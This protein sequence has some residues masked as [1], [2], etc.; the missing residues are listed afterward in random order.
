MPISD[1][2]DAEKRFAAIEMRDSVLEL[3]W[4]RILRISWLRNF[5]HE[6]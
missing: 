6:M 1:L 3:F 2:C 4:M 5:K